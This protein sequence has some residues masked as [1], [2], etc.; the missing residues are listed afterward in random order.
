MFWL[1][2][3]HVLFA[4]SALRAQGL[5]LNT[6]SEGN[7]DGKT[8]R[9]GM[10][11]AL[12]FVGLALIAITCGLPTTTV[13]RLARRY[14]RRWGNGYGIVA[15]IRNRR[16]GEVGSSRKVLTLVWTLHEIK[17]LDNDLAVIDT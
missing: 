9:N 15:T 4:R 6:A 8:Q 16:D 1:I 13:S 17:S 12:G 14:T 10:L 7:D 2:C 5:G 11:V 3:N